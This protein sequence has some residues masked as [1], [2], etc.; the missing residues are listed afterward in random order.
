MAYIIYD[1]LI[2]KNKKGLVQQVI[3]KERGK[4]RHLM[5]PKDSENKSYPHERARSEEQ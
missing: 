4:L 5:T 3:L 1:E 2:H